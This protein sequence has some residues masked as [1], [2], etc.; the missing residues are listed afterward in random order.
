MRTA[1]Q[2]A[3]E[4][5]THVREVRSSQ[6]QFQGNF[7]VTSDKSSADIIGDG[8]E[9][10][11]TALSI[12]GQGTSSSPANAMMQQGAQEGIAE[13]VKANKRSKFAEFFFG[14]DAGYSTAVEQA[15]S[16]FANN[17]YIRQM[18][19]LE[20]NVS[21]TPEQFSKQMNEQVSGKIKELYEDDVEAQAI[22]MKTW[23]KQSKKLAREQAAQHMA[24]SQQQA[25]AEG[26]RDVTGRF[27]SIHLNSQQSSTEDAKLEAQE[28][29]E[30]LLSKDFVYTGA[31]GKS[32]TSL[33]SRNIQVKAIEKQLAAGNTDVLQNLPKDFEDGLTVEQMTRLERAKQSYDLAIANEGEAIVEEG[34][35]LAEQGNLEGLTSQTQRLIALQPRLSGTDTSKDKFNED[36]RRLVSAMNNAQAKLARDSV[37]AD[38]IKAYYQAREVSDAGLAG[39]TYSKEAQEGADDLV[40][41]MSALRVATQTGEKPPETAAE[42]INVALS[43]KSAMQSIA[44][45]AEKYGSISPSFAEA[46]KQVV[47]NLRPNEE[48]YLAAEKMTELDNLR[49]LY[50]KAPGAMRKALGADGS[51]IIEIT[52]ANSR[53]PVK[54]ILNKRTN[55]VKNKNMTLSKQELN[56]PPEMTVNDYVKQQLGNQRLDS[57][58]VNHY[59][60]QL[61][62]GYKIYG[63][64]TRA[65]VNYM[66]QMY[67]VNNE[68]WRG[69]NIVNAGI[70]QTE[71]RQ[72]LEALE[73]SSMAKALIES[74]IPASV[75]DP[76][77]P[78]RGFS[79]LN[80]AQFEVHPGTNDL[81]ISS[82]QFS[83]PIVIPAPTLTTLAQKAT[84]DK[85][86]AD[87]LKVKANTEIFR[88]RVLPSLEKR[89]KP[90]YDPWSNNIR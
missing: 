7:T 38:N 90:E 46:T 82:S 2:D 32:A 56:I 84:A 13:A 66:K 47:M 35:L 9:A 21:L 10:A 22:A 67:K 42:A 8:A 58:A 39:A 85:K 64:D 28:E 6:A 49:V 26:L 51:A 88:Q 31:D 53:E 11:M 25:F 30:E 15:V 78:F 71:V 89:E 69:K 23:S 19:D 43:S 61:K 12:V 5:T 80:D 14:Q 83:Y 1:S 44:M 79:D 73:N 16:N 63:G 36:R 48:G 70:V 24:F 41:A 18:Q 52:L 34:L 20:S 62:T 3:N 81:I 72:G 54:E 40:V 29:L 76:S 86:A 68:T 75:Q 17:E 50:D 87:E 65:A 74:R 4:G 55:Y 45:K 33:A 60:E 59:S 77:K 37:K 27:D 57:A